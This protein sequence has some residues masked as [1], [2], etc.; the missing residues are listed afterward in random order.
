MCALG[1]RVFMTKL[2]ILGMEQQVEPLSQSQ[3]VFY[4]PLSQ[5]CISTEFVIDTMMYAKME[6]QSISGA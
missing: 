6:Q 3:Q 5:P 4:C 2:M 1:V